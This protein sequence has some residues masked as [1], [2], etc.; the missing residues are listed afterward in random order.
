MVDEATNLLI[1]KGAA[2]LGSAVL[3]VLFCLLP[4]KVRLN[5]FLVDMVAE[6]WIFL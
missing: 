4:L 2:I 6:I 5:G 3:S 1:T